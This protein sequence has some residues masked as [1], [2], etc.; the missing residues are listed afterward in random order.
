MMATD[1]AE[2]GYDYVCGRL[3]SSV[4]QTD[5]SRHCRKVPC[6]GVD[7]R[8]N[9]SGGQSQQK[10]PQL[11]AMLPDNADNVNV[12]FFATLIMQALNVF[13]TCQI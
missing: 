1:H 9:V 13:V 5:L 6:S 8:L 7:R 4:C 2:N 10:L 3:H 11:N 12:R